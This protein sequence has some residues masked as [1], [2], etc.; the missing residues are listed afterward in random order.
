MKKFKQLASAS[1]LVLATFSTIF[2][3][4][5]YAGQQNREQ[6][7]QEKVVEKKVK[8]EVEVH[9]V[10]V[11]PKTTI[12][13]SLQPLEIEPEEEYSSLEEVINQMDYGMEMG[14]PCGLSKEDF[15]K[16]MEELPYDY[17]GFYARN[18]EFIWEMEQQYQV[19]AIFYCGIVAQESGWAR[20]DACKN[21]YTGY[22][23]GTG[24]AAFESEE[25]GIEATFK[26]LSEEYIAKE[27]TTIGS[28]APVYLG[29]SGG[30]WDRKV[31]SAM[32]MIVSD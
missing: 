17:T 1:F 5:V 24:Y 30:T 23:S 27:L 14:K 3:G 18:A 26:L 28:I 25:A 6:L 21:N 31:Y 8:T 32:K 29:Y 11:E 2:I 15:V 7:V 16:L 10:E 20:Y 12:I 13:V 19:N 4:D 22:T 9:K